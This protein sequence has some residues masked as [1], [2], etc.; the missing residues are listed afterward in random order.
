MCR[1]TCNFPRKLAK[2]SRNL[3]KLL[4]D[5]LDLIIYYHLRRLA[6]NLNFNTTFDDK[7]LGSP[8]Q[9]AK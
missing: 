1:K 6:K 9:T 2:T 3:T 5:S 7:C 8:T 4:L